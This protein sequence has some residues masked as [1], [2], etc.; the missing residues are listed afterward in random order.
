MRCSAPSRAASQTSK[1]R[2]P[3]GRKWR[4]PSR[5]PLASPAASASP[6][7]LAPHPDDAIDARRVASAGT[8][9]SVSGSAG[10]T[11]VN[12]FTVAA[13]GGDR[14]TRRRA[15]GRR[16]A[17]IGPVSTVPHVQDSPSRW[18][19]SSQVSWV[20]LRW[21]AGTKVQARTTCPSWPRIA[22]RRT[23]AHCACG[24]SAEHAMTVG[25]EGCRGSSGRS[26]RPGGRPA[27]NTPQHARWS[28]VRRDASPTRG[29]A[30]RRRTPRA[31]ARAVHD[32]VRGRDPDVALAVHEDRA[33]AALGLLLLAG[34]A[35]RDRGRG[36]RR[37]RP[38]AS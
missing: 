3:A 16:S 7:S 29:P 12:S 25:G 4:W 23:L 18:S 38:A 34:S 33:A 26:G 10:R 5:L 15:V 36:R 24:R 27:R 6:S 20:R 28:P 30:G 22:K 13:T 17:T 31:S 2:P 1:S 21:R 37:G 35:P 11:A 19:V 32:A 14:R 8:N 9:R